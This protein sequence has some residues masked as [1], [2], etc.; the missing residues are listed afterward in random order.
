MVNQFSTGNS[1]P[2]FAETKGEYEEPSSIPWALDLPE[3]DSH[4]TQDPDESLSLV[5]GA[6]ELP[7]MDPMNLMSLSRTF[8][9]LSV[10][11]DG[12]DLET[13]ATKMRGLGEV[14]K[15]D[16]SLAMWTG[17][18]L[19][20]ETPRDAESL[21][22]ELM[23]PNERWMYD[24]WKAGAGT[25]PDGGNERQIRL[26]EFNWDEN[27]APVPGG[28]QSLKKFT[29]RA[30]AMD[31]VFGHQGATPENAAWLTFN[32]VDFLPLVKAVTKVS[33]ME[34]HSRQHG[35]TRLQGLSDVE[36]AEL[37]TA[38]RIVAA[39]DRNLNREMERFRKLKKSLNESIAIIKARVQSLDAKKGN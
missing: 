3:A 19:A 20:P 38:R 32:M 27:V 23:G 28:A 24:E 30:A 14:V 35:S 18:E 13:T 5:S 9:I 1:L 31:I 29:Q 6:P 21:A 25:T 17:L 12:D 8:H 10:P 22:K 2:S 33:N 4:G 7:Q 26:P 36:A 11:E 34:R 16:Y 39:A 15:M 37:E